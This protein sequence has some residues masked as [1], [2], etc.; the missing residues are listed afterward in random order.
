MAVS[1]SNE[2]KKVFLSQNEI[3][4]VLE[5]P[6]IIQSRDELRIALSS[7]PIVKGNVKRFTANGA[8]F[9]DGTQEKFTSIIFATGENNQRLI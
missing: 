4:E 3:D 8:E 5:V 2:A 7:K 6:E 1:I 9:M